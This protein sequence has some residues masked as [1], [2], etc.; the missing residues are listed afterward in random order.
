MIAREQIMITT[1]NTIHYKYQGKFEEANKI[2]VSM[3][4]SPNPF[5]ATE[6]K[7]RQ[8]SHICPELMEVLNNKKHVLM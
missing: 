3:R 7:N 8:I 2:I 1:R 4:R 5:T 6:K